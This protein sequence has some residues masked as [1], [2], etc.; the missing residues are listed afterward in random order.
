[1]NRYT[2][3]ESKQSFANTLWIA[4]LCFS[5]FITMLDK[6]ESNLNVLIVLESFYDRVSVL[7][8]LFN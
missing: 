3:N 6:V 7:L 4:W 8:P 2:N 5:A 1:M